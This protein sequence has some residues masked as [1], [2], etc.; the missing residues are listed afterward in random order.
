V[1]KHLRIAFATFSTYC[2]G[3]L[4]T[5]IGVSLGCLASLVHWRGFIRVGTSVWSRFLFWIVGRNPHVSGR[6]N[7]VPGKPF[8]VVSNHASMYDIPALMTAVPGIAIMGRDYLL[9]IPVFG[10]FLRT[11]HYVPIDTSSGRSARAALSLAAAEIRGGTSVGIFVEGTRTPTGRV[12]PLKRGFVTV[13]RESGSDLLP[14]FIRGT[15]ALNPKGK[16]YIDPRE[17]I[18]IKIGA[19]IANADLVRLDDGEIMHKVKSILEQMGDNRS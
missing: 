12:Q 17:Q 15:Y 13:L 5:A 19:P 10:Q 7:L 3:Y 11:L 18:T 9:R 16:K 6:E 4:F 1:K 14:V 8:L 2:V